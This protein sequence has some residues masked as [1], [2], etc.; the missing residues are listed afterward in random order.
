M[1]YKI[2][3]M[4]FSN[5]FCYN[6]LK[7][8]NKLINHILGFANYDFAN[9]GEKHLI[10]SLSKEIK[11][12]IDVGAGEGSFFELIESSVKNQFFYYA[13]EPNPNSYNILESTLTKS[14]IN[15]YKIYNK[16]V[17]DKDEK[18]NLYFYKDKSKPN[19]SSLSKDTYDILYQKEFDSIQVDVLKLDSLID[20]FKNV[21]LIK[22]DTEGNL[23]K[24]LIGAQKLIKIKTLKY[25]LFELN[26][27][28]YIQGVTFYEI[29]NL[30]GNDFK[31]YRLLRNGLIEINNKNFLIHE[32]GCNIIAKRSVEL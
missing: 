24:V 31:F 19:H 1:I 18:L 17:G 4:L 7:K 2:S 6:F 23:S 16:A 25:I 10:E 21:D 22:I 13:F 9:S 29:S 27:N 11:S 30:I 3:M 5:R 8:C 20:E 12:V 28:E 32:F 26:T 15:N 14:R